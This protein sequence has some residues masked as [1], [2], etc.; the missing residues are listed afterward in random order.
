MMYRLLLLLIMSFNAL[1]ADVE[2]HLKRGFAKPDPSQHQMQNIDFIYMINLESRPEKFSSCAEQLNPYGIHPFRFSAIYGRELTLD[3]INDV[4][5][6]FEPW[7]QGGHWGTS[8]L[9]GG[10]FTPFH[11]LVHVLDRVYFCHCMG[12]APIAIVLSHLSVL[13]DAYDSGYETIWVMEDDIQVI[14]DPKII[15]GLITKLDKLTGKQWDILFDGPRHKEFPR[16]ICA[17]PGLCME[18]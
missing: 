18:A 17:L 1:S 4:G 16:R 3:E 14:R 8:Y 6:K 13:Q 15:P 5:V 9:P 12:R 10:D 7:M 2:D 11:D